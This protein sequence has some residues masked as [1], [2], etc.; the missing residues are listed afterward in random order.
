MSTTLGMRIKELRKEKKITLENLA[1]KSNISLRRLWDIE[2]DKSDPK[3]STLISIA[4]ALET[5]VT[6]LLGE[7]E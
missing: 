1:N 3:T 7:A 2:L 4:A 5:K 6:Y